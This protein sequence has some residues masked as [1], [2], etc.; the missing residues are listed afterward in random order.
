M[1]ELIE[2]PI[3]VYVPVTRTEPDPT[4]DFKHEAKPV[5]MT[6]DNARALRAWLE[7]NLPPRRRV[8]AQPK[9]KKPNGPKKQ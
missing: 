4:G 9:E 1:P 6:L 3:I 2:Y 5:P 7:A 8:M